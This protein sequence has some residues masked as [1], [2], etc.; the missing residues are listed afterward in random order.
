MNRAI[1]HIKYLISKVLV[2]IIILFVSFESSS[3]TVSNDSL[4]GVEKLWHN[5][6]SWCKE[7]NVATSLDGGVTLGSMGL[8]LEIK[9]PLTKWVDLRAGID[10]L[11]TFTVP[12][13]FNLNTYSDGIP[14]GNFNHV[15]EMVYE[16]TGI[17][18]DETVNMK[19][20]GHMLN[21]KLLFDV[22]PVPSNRHWH[23]TAGFFAG[24]SQIAKAINTYAEK[25]TLV[26]L[27]IYNR[28]YEYFTHLEDI[29]DVPLGG[30]IYM[31]PE[32]VEKLQQRFNDYGRMGVHIGDFKDG[33]PYI[34][35]PAPDGTI[36]A[37]AF[38]NHFKPYLGAGYSTDID[39]EGRWHF[40]IDLGALFWGGDPDVIN[41]DYRTGKDINFTKDLINIRGKV[42]SYMKTIRA[43][44]IYPVLEV[45]FS[46]TIL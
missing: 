36:S 14:T 26:G 27:N 29:Y 1:G 9:T 25:P 11:P 32:M 46:Y 24:T 2:L 16:M 21:F 10:W 4:K 34:M 7:K 28:G 33:T 39:R 3:Q 12:M 20:K 6:S 35:E 45:R 19:G 41:H 8:G 15:A 30:G 43:L 22:F 42:G 5:V 17:H 13:T 31:D 23:V 18:I 38:V 44:P 37:K 40:G